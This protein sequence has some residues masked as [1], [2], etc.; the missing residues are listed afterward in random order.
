MDQMFLFQAI[1]FVASKTLLH[2]ILFSIFLRLL[3]LPTSLCHLRRCK[4]KAM[5]CQPFALGCQNRILLGFSGWRLHSCC[6][7]LPPLPEE[8]WNHWQ[9]FPID[10]FCLR[11]V[12]TIEPALYDRQLPMKFLALKTSCWKSM[13][14]K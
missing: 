12:M 1:V 6:I 11:R 14:G 8:C 4:C 9:N 5:T 13:Q 10:C 2:T 3:P 7:M